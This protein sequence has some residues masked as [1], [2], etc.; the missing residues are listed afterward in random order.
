MAELKTKATDQD[1]KEFLNTIT[2]E[3]KRKDSFT[4]LELF[5][6]VTGEKPVMWI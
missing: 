2:P 5:E 4:L 3:Q 1:P 6:K